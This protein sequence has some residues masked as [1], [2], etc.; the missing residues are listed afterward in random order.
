MSKTG[1]A[2]LVGGFDIPAVSKTLIQFEAGA[3]SVKLD[4]KCMVT[5]VGSW[6]DVTAGYEAAIAQIDQGADFL[7]CNGNAVGL[8]VIQAARE[9]GAYVFGMTTDRSNLVPDNVLA[10]DV[11]YRRS[12]I[13]RCTI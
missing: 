7:F 8:G 1:K 9:R 6:E 4:F 13:S 5:Y 3:K 2:R 11:L 10:S 12:E